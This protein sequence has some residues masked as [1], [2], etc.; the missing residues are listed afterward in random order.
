MKPQ[1][2]VEDWKG[3]H[4]TD[5][6]NAIVEKLYSAIIAYGI[7]KGYYVDTK[8]ITIIAYRSTTPP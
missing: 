4:N 7:G 1:I 5:P 8:D 6:K 2:V 3:K